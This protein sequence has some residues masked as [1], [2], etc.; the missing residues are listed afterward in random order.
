MD[1]RVA[2]KRSR[3]R[4]RPVLHQAPRRSPSAMLRE[5][6]RKKRGSGIRSKM[7]S[8]VAMPG[9]NRSKQPRQ[10]AANALSDAV[11]FFT[12]APRDMPTAGMAKP[13]GKGPVPMWKPIETTRSI[14]DLSGANT[15]IRA[16]EPWRH[17]RL[18][19]IVKKKRCTLRPRDMMMSVR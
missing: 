10:S 19:A 14:D 12:Q 4:N 13:A 8:S 17:W 15:R 3:Q 6:E 18:L 1:P 5:I 9:G 16:P 2:S 7:S 11:F